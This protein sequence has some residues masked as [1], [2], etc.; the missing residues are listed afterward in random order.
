MQIRLKDWFFLTYN[1][2]YVRK[3]L[4]FQDENND[5]IKT[6]IDNGYNMIFSNVDALYL[7]CGFSA[8]IGDG[9]NWCSPY[10]SKNLE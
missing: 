2:K 4:I 7:D 9:H 5:Q 3:I 8:W 10:K 1:S 6:L